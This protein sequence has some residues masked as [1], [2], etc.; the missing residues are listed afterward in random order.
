MEHDGLFGKTRTQLG[1]GAAFG[2]GQVKIFGVARRGFYH[3]HITVDR[4]QVLPE[5][6]DIHGRLHHFGNA[7]IQRVVI[8]IGNGAH[9]RK[10]CFTSRQA[11]RFIDQR[12]RNGAMSA[13]TKLKQRDGVTHAALRQLAKQ[14][15]GIMFEHDALLFG[16]VQKAV[17]QNGG[18]NTAKIKALATRNDSRRQFMELCGCQNKD[19]VSGRLLQRFEQGVER[20]ARQHMDLVDDINAVF[21]RVGGVNDLI[22]NIADIFY[23]VVRGGVHL[24]H[25]GRRTAANG[26]AGCTLAAGRAADWMLTVDRLGQNLSTGRLARAS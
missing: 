22:A 20:A 19:H 4:N 12:G 15:S 23:A 21:E 16:N 8:L 5:H 9:G 14:R 6:A 2:V 7:R 13:R 10:Q 26:T 24:K 11:H 25:V 3:Q 17:A 1:Q 18:G